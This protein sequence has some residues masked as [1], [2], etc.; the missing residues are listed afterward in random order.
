MPSMGRTATRQRMD[1][2]DTLRRKNGTRL[3]CQQHSIL[4]H[5]DLSLCY[6]AH[7]AIPEMNIGAIDLLSS[8]YIF[9]NILPP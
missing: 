2:F 5:L 9:V 3:F 6:L 8:L 4:L 7:P 1:R